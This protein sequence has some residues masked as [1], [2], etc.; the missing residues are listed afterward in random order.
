MILAIVGSRNFKDY[1]VLNREINSLR[2]LYSITKIISGCASGADTLAEKY[3]VENDLLFE[4]YNANW[5]EFKSAAGIIR[6][7]LI[8][9]NCDLLI[10]FWD[11]KSRGTMDTINKTKKLNKKVEIIRF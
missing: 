6:N 1:E 2:N 9:K 11:G 4:K 5:K 3:S 8:A 10:A 7:T